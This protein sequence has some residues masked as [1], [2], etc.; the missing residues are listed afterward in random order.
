MFYNIVRCNECS[1]VY[2]PEVYASVSPE[3]VGLTNEGLNSNHIWLQTKHKEPAFHQCARLVRSFWL[4]NS[5]GRPVRK[6]LDVGCGV[7]GWLDFSKPDYECYGFDA[8]PIQS[9]YAMRRFPHV[10]C[11]VSFG[12]YQSQF[13]N[14]LPSFDLITLWDV[15]EHIRTPLELMGELIQILSPDGLFF[16]SVPAATPM[17]IKNQMLSVGWPKARFSWNPREHVAYYSPTT[18]RMLC[19]KINLQVLSL[20]S[21]ALYPRPLSAFEVVRR[22]GFWITTAIPQLA[23]QIY[24]LAKRRHP[25]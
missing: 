9:R 16:A 24:V 17:V 10:R 8:S 7:G 11:A 25:N 14:K 13:E 22:L 15:L 3:Y 4:T 23:P 18:L 19:E 5:P 12:E 1:L 21:V 20:G 6:L 2:I